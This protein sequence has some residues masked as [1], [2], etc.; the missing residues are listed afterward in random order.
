MHDTVTTAWTEFAAAP[1]D[2][3]WAPDTS[4]NDYYLDLCVRA[5]P[6]ICHAFRKTSSSGTRRARRRGKRR[7]QRVDEPRG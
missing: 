2:G 5:F 6:P 3:R 4:L 1:K 7:R